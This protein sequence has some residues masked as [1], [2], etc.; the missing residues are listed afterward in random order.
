MQKLEQLEQ[1]LTVTEKMREEKE[2]FKVGGR[3][4]GC[5]AWLLGLPLKHAWWPQP[6]RPRRRR[7]ARSHA[8]G[9]TLG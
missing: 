2:K 3:D 5:C 1:Q 8:C 9:R 6:V 4:A 7:G